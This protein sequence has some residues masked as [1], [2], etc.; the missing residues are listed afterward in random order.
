MYV[1][2]SGIDRDK[3]T[4]YLKRKSSIREI[5]VRKSSFDDDIRERAAFDY[6]VH[7][8]TEAPRNFIP[9]DDAWRDV[10]SLVQSLDIPD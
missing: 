7:V 3:I 1:R 10:I 6:E 9:L 2:R 4:E 5:E 8:K